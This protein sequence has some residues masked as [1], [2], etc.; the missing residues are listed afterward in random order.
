MVNTNMSDMDDLS[1]LYSEVIEES[2]G[3]AM[4]DKPASVRGIKPPQETSMSIS[5]KGN[6]IGGPE[7]NLAKTSETSGQNPYEQEEDMGPIQKSEVID[8]IDSL[9]GEL[10][11]ASHQDQVALMVLGKL[12]KMIN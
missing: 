1:D 6:R 8:M 3:G 7:F 2:W 4:M 5:Y 11:S 12:K 10:D 9:V